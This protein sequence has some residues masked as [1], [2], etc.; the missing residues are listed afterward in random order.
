MRAHAV[1]P[2]GVTDERAPAA[3]D[4]EKALARLQP[5][6]AADHVE[7]VVLRSREVI[8]RLAEIGAG[9]DH[10]GIEKELVERVREV[11]V[12]VNVLAVSR[13]GAVPAR[14][15]AA[16][17]SSGNGPPRGTNRK[18]AP[19]LNASVLSSDLSA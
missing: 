8:V 2:R 6:L 16:H 3:A 18:R 13:L 4:V 14:L 7:L 10:L 11:V 12:V 17:R 19:V 15:V 9:V 5:Q 1:I